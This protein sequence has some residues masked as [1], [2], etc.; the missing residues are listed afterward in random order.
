MSKI[1]LNNAIK[2]ETFD[3]D[4]IISPQETVKRFKDKLK[5][6]NLDI[7]EKT[8][9][10]D[11]GRLDIPVFFSNCGSDAQAVIG[12]KKQ[13]GKGGTPQQAEASAVMELAERF[14]FFSFDQNP[15][16]F[17]IE[18]YKNIKDR[19]MDYEQIIKSVHDNAGDASRA[20]E[21]F[22][23]LD[24]K[25]TK[26]YNLTKDEEVLIPFDW[27]FTINQFNGSC[28]GNCNEEAL[29]Q[30]I[31]EVVERHVSSLVSSNNLDVPTIELES[32]TDPLCLE[33]IEK[34]EKAG[35]KLWISDFTLDTGIP[36]IGVLA[37]DPATFPLESEIVW[38]AGT[39]PAPQKALSRALSETAQLGGDFN[40]GSNYVASGLPKFNNIKEA[41]FI[42][43]SSKSIPITKLP[44]LSHNNI[45][46]EISGLVSILE[47]N[48]MDVFIVNTT[49]PDLEIPGFYIII[50]GTYFRER[51]ENS[52]V[53]MFCTKLISENNHPMFAIPELKKAAKLLPEKYYIQ[54]Y[55]GTSFIN[56]DEPETALKHLEHALELNPASQDIPS[57][58]SYMGVCFRDMEKYLQALEILEKGIAIDPERIDIHN[59][60]GFC[61]FKLKEH[62]KAIE[63]FNRV[64]Q[65]N[66]GSAIDYANIASNYREMGNREKAINYYEMALGIDSSIEFAR[67]SLE[68]LKNQE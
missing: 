40:S 46:T 58:Y 25:W 53:G 47:K 64:L 35:I 39:T 19:A 12:N 38:T 65:I 54:F 28:A 44:D 51:A 1:I 17:I 2:Q 63:C 5:N 13:M 23:N 55:L 42:T 34:Y 14:S 26:G 41:D 60:M 11:N 67:E 6:I 10:I 24:L 21:I 50:P 32:I 66:P 52:S 29:N 61:Y 56:I 22:E 62:E 15:E 30:G 33:M 9:R 20:M 68:R 59:L 43:K 3:Q 48:N 45:K 37:Y 7:L 16:N 36:T 31:C 49:H 27:F 8:V 57:I 18:K 4:K